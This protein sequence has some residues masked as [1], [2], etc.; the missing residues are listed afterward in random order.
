VPN[1]VV[2]LGVQVLEV[3]WDDTNSLCLTPQA[4]KNVPPA[5]DLFNA[6]N[7]QFWEVVLP[8]CDALGYV[9]CTGTNF[10]LRSQSLANVR[11]A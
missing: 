11:H 3:M 7:P 1:H 5:A 8:G 6:I 10:C 2:V 4:F 9:A